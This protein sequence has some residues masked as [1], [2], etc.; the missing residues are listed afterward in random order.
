MLVDLLSDANSDNPRF[1]NQYSRLQDVLQTIFERLEMGF[2]EQIERVI[3]VGDWT[4][5]GIDLRNLP[6]DEVVVEI[7]LS[8]SERP[9]KLYQQLAQVVFSDLHD[10]DIH[11]QFRLLTLQEWQHAESLAKINGQENM[12]GITLLSRL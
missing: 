5:F 10:E 8:S 11:V 12:L 2:D 3:G 7:V 4:R 9:F 6:Y 1:E